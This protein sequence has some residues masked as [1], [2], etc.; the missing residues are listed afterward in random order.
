MFRTRSASVSHPGMVSIE[1]GSL[2]PVYIKSLESQQPEIRHQCDDGMRVTLTR[3]SPDAF[4]G[5]LGKRQIRLSCT[6]NS[7]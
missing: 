3:M 6:F 1:S 2:L 5:D 7:F 4:P